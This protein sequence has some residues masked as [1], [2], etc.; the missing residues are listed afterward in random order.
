MY[1]SKLAKCEWFLE[2]TFRGNISPLQLHVSVK[3]GGISSLISS[4]TSN[5]KNTHNS[6]EYLVSCTTHAPVLY[7]YLRTHPL[8]GI[9]VFQ[10]LP[11]FKLHVNKT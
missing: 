11:D 6:Y 9:F 3:A 1:A 8:A 10:L 4:I 5:A 7:M 2:L